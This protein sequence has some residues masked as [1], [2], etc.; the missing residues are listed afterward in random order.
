MSSHPAQVEAVAADHTL[1]R[2]FN[3]WSAFAFAFAFISPIVALYGIFGLAYSTAG[4]SF[5]WNFLIV[6]GGQLLVAMV[7]AELVSRWPIEGSIYQWSRRLLG[8]GYGWSAGWFYMWTLVVAMSSVAMFAAGF[9]ANVFGWD[10]SAGQQALVAW[11]ILILGT[12]ANIAGRLVLKILMTGSIIAEI[13]GS[14][15]LGA[16]LLLFH[17]DNS[18]GVLTHGFHQHGYLSASGPFLVAMA[19]VGWSFVGFESAGAIAEEVHQPRRNLPKAVIFS[20]TFIALV[21]MFSALAITLA[22]P[23]EIA[24]K[25]SDPVYDTLAFQLGSGAA[26]LAE[27]LFTVGFLASF[28]ALQTS[29]SRMIWSYARD[30]ALPAP[31][32]LAKLTARQ[33]QPVS[34]LLV[35]TTIGTVIIILGQLAPN[36]YTLLL[37]F[38]SGGFYL[39]FLF[40]LVGNIVVR[41][42]GEWRSGPFSLGRWSMVVS[43]AALLWATFQFL[44]IAW[45]RNF[46]PDAPYLNWSMALAVLGLA[47][48]GAVIYVTRRR[49]ITTVSTS[50]VDDPIDAAGSHVH[51]ATRSTAAD[52][53]NTPEP[54]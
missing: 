33:K 6:F 22:I 46:Y 29:A 28:L 25:S 47:V 11:V 5:W 9:V 10:L 1:K 18:L 15:G 45:P 35:A 37:N 3:L 53:R 30:R 43:V 42:R 13:V 4:P 2:E 23:P 49:H 7:F 50:D 17:R 36:F 32:L 8:Q 39:A 14:L 26:K 40:P 24:A 16:W 12:T 54:A 38:T 41:L 48:V 19:F 20:I 31:N 52:R 21:V 44:N 27:V 34:A 51:V